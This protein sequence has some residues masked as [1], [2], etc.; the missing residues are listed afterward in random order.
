MPTTK[1][2]DIIIDKREIKD[3]G[4][5]RGVSD[6]TLADRTLTVDEICSRLGKYPNYARS[7]TK[8]SLW[9]EPDWAKIEGV[10]P[11]VLYHTK[12]IRD[13]LATKPRFVLGAEIDTTDIMQYV[14][15]VLYVKE[16]S[17]S[18]MSDPKGTAT[19]REMLLDYPQHEMPLW[20]RRN[21]LSMSGLNVDKVKDAC[22][23][24]GFPETL[25]GK[26]KSAYLERVLNAGEPYYVICK[27]TALGVERL[28]DK[29]FKTK[30]EAYEYSR[31]NLVGN[32][33]GNRKLKGSTLVGIDCPLLDFVNRKGPDLRKGVSADK[34]TFLNTFGITGMEFGNWVTNSERKVMLNYLY[35]TL[36]DLATVLKVPKNVLSLQA[37][38]AL[39]YSYGARG[40]SYA[41]GKVAYVANDDIIRMTRVDNAGYFASAYSVALDY[42]IGSLIDNGHKTSFIGA[43]LGRYTKD[44]VKELNPGLYEV[45]LTVLNRIQYKKYSRG[46]KK[47]DFYIAIKKQLPFITLKEIYHRCFAAYVYTRLAEKGIHNDFLVFDVSGFGTSKYYPQGEELQFICAAFDELF[48][49]VF[50]GTNRGIDKEYKES[51]DTYAEYRDSYLDSEEYILHTAEVRRGQL[52]LQKRLMSIVPGIH[53]TNNLDREMLLLRNQAKQR[54]IS[55]FC[56]VPLN[57]ILK[58]VN[59]STQGFMYNAHK[60]TL[61]V[62]VADSQLKEYLYTLEG[63]LYG[64]MREQVGKDLTAEQG[65]YVACATAVY[66]QYSTGKSVFKSTCLTPVY[67]V[68]EKDPYQSSK[69]M[70]AVQ[71]LIQELG[72]L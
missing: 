46:K 40:R 48:T 69:L 23:L 28:S 43:L 17:E 7:I 36:S 8:D 42:Y 63:V 22:N 44:R 33:K 52:S 18:V 19:Y 55:V 53:L 47:S 35:D 32:I 6:R 59:G 25:V 49:Q 64:L 60:K 4:I 13:K 21:L 2:E 51:E 10:E 68:I 45:G 1:Q 16:C 66:Y 70:D 37:D 71:E 50:K 24:M 15:F 12:C 26:L 57:R 3:F 20:L 34:D 27:T 31:S 62:G 14:K 67:R 38:T 58:P 11:E 65:L 54:G 41:T 39:G 30:E 9:A 5:V 72:R 29:L 56:K 61:A